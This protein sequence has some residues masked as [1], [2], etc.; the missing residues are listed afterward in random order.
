[1]GYDKQEE[2]REE[3]KEVVVKTEPIDYMAMMEAIKGL[4]NM[5]TMLTQNQLNAGVPSRA[6]DQFPRPPVNV[7]APAST[8]IQPAPSVGLTGFPVPPP[9]GCRFCR[10]PGHFIRECLM[11]EEYQMLKELSS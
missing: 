10:T 6:P 11:V 8:F 9:T 3:R 5:M 2:K 1:M 4:T 7:F